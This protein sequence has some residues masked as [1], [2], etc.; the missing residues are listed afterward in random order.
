VRHYLTTPKLA[1]TFIPC[2]HPEFWA[3]GF[4]YGDLPRLNDADFQVGEKTYGIYGHDWRVRPPMA[5]LALMA[6]REVGTGGP[7]HAPATTQPLI[8]LSQEEFAAAVRLALRDYAHADTLTTNPLLQSRVVMQKS[9]WDA[10]T[11]ARII[12]LQALIKEAAES[13]Q[14]TPKSAKLYRAIY[15]TYLRP[16]PSQEQAAEILDVPFSTFRR[17]LKDGI[18]HIA[19]HLWQKEIGG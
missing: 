18:D 3:P 14:A 10:L 13:L 17:H 12:A 19:E 5:W 9:G 1:F 6:E 15:H 11:A 2:A 7:T 8:V 4:A 16:A